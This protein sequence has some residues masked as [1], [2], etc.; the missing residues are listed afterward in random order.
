MID[1]KE[2]H[3]FAVTMFIST[4]IFGALLL[5]RKGQVGFIFWEIGVVILITG[6]VLPSLLSPIYR[7]WMKLA[8]LLGVVSS[9]IVLAIMYYFVFTPIGLFIRAIGRDPLQK[10]IN[11]N[12][13]SY[14]IKRERKSIVKDQYEKMF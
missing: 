1:A 2:I 8:L 13:K 3:K 12:A 5:W 7:A 4:V 6:F 9:H 10:R 14:W 11:I